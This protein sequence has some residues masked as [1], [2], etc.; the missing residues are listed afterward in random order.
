[1]LSIL[2]ADD[3]THIRELYRIRL[4][5]RGYNVLTASDG[6]EAINLIYS[7]KIDLIILDVMMPKLNGFEVL[8]MIRS[9]DINIPVI[10]V[11][12]KGELG[13]K[14]EGFSSGTDDYLVKPF[15]FDELLFRIEALVKRYKIVTENKLVVGKTVLDFETLTVENK[16]ENHKITLS[17][18]EF[19]I[20]F[21]L[22]SYPEKSFTKEQ[23]F[24]EF[25][26]FDTNADL[27]SVKVYVSKIR[28]Q[29]ADFK[30]IDIETIR[31]IGYRGVK[32]EKA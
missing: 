29:I 15:E 14:R 26:G 8:N 30:E 9:D 16:E 23:L 25:W 12:A 3:E 21:K 5:K 32:N 13:D 24:D 19:S 27:D 2:V 7:K 20:L 17:K 18:K 10:L 31:G 1:M 6:L 4:T 11:T 28:K 22:L